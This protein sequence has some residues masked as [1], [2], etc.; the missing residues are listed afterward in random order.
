[1][2]VWEILHDCD[3]EETGKATCWFTKI[4]H[5][6]YGENAF[7]AKAVEGYNVEVYGSTDLIVLK[8]CKSLTSAKRWVSTNLIR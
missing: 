2:T 1:M 7:I 5:D 4:D 6:K 8:N 3:D